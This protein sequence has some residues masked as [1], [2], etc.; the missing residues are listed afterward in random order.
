VLTSAD[1]LWARGLRLYDARL[2]DALGDLLAAGELLRELKAP[3]PAYAAWRSE[4]ALALLALDQRTGG[5]R[6]AP[7]SS[8]WPAPLARHGRWEWRYGH[9]AWWNAASRGSG[10]C[11]KRCRR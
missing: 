10:S 1:L 3:N 6:S 8:S 5:R 9:P 7:R 11:A 2:E 4:A